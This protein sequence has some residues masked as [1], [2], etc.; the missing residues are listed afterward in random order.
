MS[1][2]AR[3]SPTLY[4]SLAV[5]V[6]VVGILARISAINTIPPGLNQDEA[7]TG[8]DAWAVLTHGIDRNGTPWPVHFIS[9]G[10]GQNALYAW[11]AMPFIATFGLNPVSLRLPML[12]TGVLS[13]PL[14]WW[15]GH[16]L[17]SPMAGLGALVCVALSPWHI[18]LSRWALESN[19]LPFVFLCGVACL[20]HAQ[21]VKRKTLW[22]LATFACLALCLYAYGPAYLAVPIFVISVVIIGIV[23][24][25]VSW[26]LALGGLAVF[27]L[28]ALPI[29][30]FLVVNTFKL[31][32]IT[33]AGV[34]MPRMPATPRFQSQL[35]EGGGPLAHAGTLWQL[36]TTQRDGTLYNITDPYGVLYS[37]IFFV[38]ALGFIVASVMQVMRRRWPAHCLL[39]TLWV[40]ACLPTGIVQESNINRINLLLMGLVVAAGIG[41]AVLD[42]RIKGAFL[43]GTLTLFALFGLFTRD[44]FTTQ[45]GKI[46]PE[47]FDGLLPALQHAQSQPTNAICVSSKVNMPYIYALFTERTDPRAFLRTVQYE[48]ASAAFRQVHAFGRYTFG[49]ERCDF[50]ATQIVIARNDEAPPA[51]FIIDHSFAQFDVYKKAG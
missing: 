31:N 48:D 47:F 21:N 17:F 6:M 41:L 42:A 7:S 2:I 27:A 33:F 18:M 19:I 30:L 38:I 4:T 9:W 12:I 40:V 24:R 45:R 11:L 15:I 43:V 44:Y 20:A 51:P 28:V 37:V 10:S 36:L 3:I 32:T 26:R 39:I 14:A 50:S 13:L 25:M 23:S 29:G 34:S 49:L 8:Y 22:W 5:I 16:R 1:R 35:L 46:A